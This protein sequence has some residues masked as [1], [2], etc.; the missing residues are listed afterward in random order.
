MEAGVREYR[1]HA[2]EAT[3]EAL[4]RLRRAWAGYHASSEALLVALAEGG[5]VRI[6]VEGADVEPA[7]AAYR[8]TAELVEARP[9]QIQQL[10]QLAAPGAFGGGG[11]D[12]VVFRSETWIEAPDATG[13]GSSGDAVVQFTGSPLQRSPSAAAVCAVDDAVVVATAAGT[14]LL[15]RCGLQPLTLDATTEPAAIARFLAERQYGA[16]P[17]GG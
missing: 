11:N 14:G 17:A 3:I 2:T 13:A 8:L 6:S 7:L 5:T 12:V 10:E 4:R 1:Y 9:E 16:G 15:V